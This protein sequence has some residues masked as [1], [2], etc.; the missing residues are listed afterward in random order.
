MYGLREPFRKASTSIWSNL[1][2]NQ[3]PCVRPQQ[4]LTL[5]LILIR[6]LSQ[7]LHKHPL[8]LMFTL[9]FFNRPVLVKPVLVVP[10]LVGSVLVT[11]IAFCQL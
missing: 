6:F 3:I 2:P 8:S 11:M 1:D 9:V 10:V 4:A 5:T 7:G